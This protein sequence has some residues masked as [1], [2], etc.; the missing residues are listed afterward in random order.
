MRRLATFVAVFAGFGVLSGVA[1]ARARADLSVAQVT[2]VPGRVAAGGRVTLKV[3]VKNRGR[4]K[5]KASK[6]TVRIGPD[7][8][9][10]GGNPIGKGRVGR[11][12]AKGSRKLRIKV[13]IPTSTGPS[14][15]QLTACVSPG[16][17]ANDCRISKAI[18]V[19][20]GSSWAKIEADRNAGKLAPAKALLYELY[21]L[22]TDRRLPK[23]YRGTGNLPSSVIFASLAAIF[24]TLSPAEQATIL[25]YTLQ[26]RYRQSAWAPGGSS[27]SASAEAA[28]DCD[29]LRDVQGAW[30]G[31]E[32]NHAWFW[33][34][35]G[36]SAAHARARSLAREFE[37][38]IWP[39]LTSN[40]KTVDDASAAPCDPAGD[41]KVDIYLVAP[42]DGG[43][44]DNRGVTPPVMIG[45]P[46][47]PLPS[48]V[49]IPEGARRSVLAHEFMH[50]IQWNFK[51]ACERAPAWTE[52]TATWAEDFVYPRDQREHEYAF[53][54]QVPFVS[55]IAPNTQ[56]GYHAWT[57][58][59]S[60]FKKDGVDGIKRVF[61]ALATHDFA[62]ALEAGPSDGLREAW[63]RYA[64]QVWNQTPI[65][66]S[67]FSEA[68]SFKDSA[69]DSFG[70]K[71]GVVDAPIS[72][73]SESKKEFTLATSIQSPLSTFFHD[74]RIDDRKV[75]HL[76]FDNGDAGRPDAAVQAFL[77]LANGR[78]RYEDWS[79]RQSVSFCRDK[80]EEDVVRM[81]VATSN[82][83]PRGAQL[84]IANHR[85]TA[86]NACSIPSTY[87]G[88]VGG[89]ASY[90]SSLLGAGNS[91]EAS[92]SGTINLVQIPTGSDGYP[93]FYQVD[94]AVG[95]AIQYSVA[96]Q[97]G[98]CDIAGQESI[99]LS[100]LGAFPIGVLNVNGG[101]PNTYGLI[102]PMA[103]GPLNFLVT[104]SNCANPANNGTMGWLPTIGIINIVDSA[105]DSPVAAD[106]G[107]RGSS[108]LGNGVV[109]QTS[110]W[111][112]TPGG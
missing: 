82:T 33:Y 54:I 86:K 40:F 87:S 14:S 29:N 74:V 73:G 46:C 47:G 7:H 45:D 98:N 64:R 80:P 17:K 93:A 21:A 20:D 84:G 48:F 72:I 59:Y 67:G 12:A 107:L 60:L 5:G 63:K 65:G 44:G 85:L 110:T 23:R 75:R 25:P 94:P 106:G 38:K 11:V 32:A 83:S 105:L 6:V 81:I 62:G 70:V 19:V 1:E 41:S 111:D 53:G 101:D 10:A 90:D 35:P 61:D 8:G 28:P 52:G 55:M 9:E 89:T 27:A 112:L 36:R 58:W 109:P 43:L 77:K 95:G 92:W 96:G 51:V 69:W 56:V 16:K 88:S 39:K 50:V 104:K 66:A 24:P 4:G 3:T 30:A 42:G 91:A 2:G 71:P 108:T 78:W 18:D 79:A 26:P 76:R 100:E 49:V 31:V 102:V 97:I 13:R 99:D 22:D 37:G 34:R 68:R 15:W 57:F 103:Q